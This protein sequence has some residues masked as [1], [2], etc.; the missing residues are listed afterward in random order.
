MDVG[1]A[2][3]RLGIH[4]RTVDD[5]T[6][7]ATYNILAADTPSQLDDLR[8]ALT[9]IA[10]SKGSYLINS[11]LNTG[12]VSSEHAASEWPVGLENIGNTCYLNSLL[13]FYFTVEPLREL[14][15]QF[16][17]YKMEIEEEG[18]RT[19]QVGSRRVSRKEVERAQRCQSLLQRQ[20]HRLC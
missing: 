13:Q 3:T 20:L 1:Q 6:I 11:F 7:L 10:K 14:V 15:L 17:Q 4:D 2:Y 19:K 8:R 12:M 5:D 16:D 9:A 18:L